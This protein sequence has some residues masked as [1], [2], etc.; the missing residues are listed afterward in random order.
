MLKQSLALVLGALLVLAQPGTGLA[1]APTRTLHAFATHGEPL[2][3]PEFKHLNYVNPQAPRGGEVTLGAPPTFDN[4][5]PFILKGV[6]APG[7]GL[8]ND[9][10]LAGTADDPE[11]L[12]GLVAESL[13]VPDDRSW[14]IFTLRQEARFHDGRPMTPADVVWSFDTLMTKGHPQYR[15]LYAD[16][17]NA[18]ALDGRRV[19]FT[20]KVA[21][22]RELPGLVGGV[23][24]LSKHYWDGRDF[25]KTTLD[26]PLGSGPY[27]IE[28]VD[29]GRS[30]RYRRVEDYWGDRLPINAGRHN[31]GAI[32]FES[33]RELSIEFEAFKA[34]AI[35]YRRE[36]QSKDWATGYDVPAVKAGIIKRDEVMNQNPLPT[37]AFTYNAR[38]ALFQDRRVRQA[39]G[40]A[41]DFEWMNKTLFYGLYIRISSYW[42]NSELAATGLPAGEERE[43]L[44]RYRGRV[45]EEVFT[46]EYK[47]PATDGSGNIRD[48]L[49]EALKLLHEAGWDIKANKLVNAKGDPFRFEIL[50]AQAG[51]ERVILPFTKNLE[52]LGITATA[53]FVDSAQYQNRADAFDYDMIIGGY[54]QSLA[55]GNEQRDFWTSASADIRGSANESGVKDP[56]VDEL[57][58][59][60]ISAPDRKSLIQRA[61]ALDRVLLWGFYMTPLYYGPSFLI[62]YWDKF[63]RPPTPPKY[64]DGFIDTWWI[65]QTKASSLAE[66]KAAM[67]N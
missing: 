28:A 43:I 38:R 36:Y 22:N 19:K 56:V 55:P 30:I 9:T 10:L 2:Y 20:F 24:V 50:Y 23:P 35:D 57:V 14:V 63:G 25:E 17:A 37:Q 16:V 34:G 1:Q 62:A 64:T 45:P 15:T 13:E 7:L 21:N 66:R 41:Y 49:R 52:R 59:L 47:P 8:I 51:L 39:L 11:G 18:A 42:T 67:K 26:P 33:Y 61:R 48:N 31:F 58:Q 32:S 46:R 60:V 65:D 54:A 40:Y 3:G 6:S 27:R 4:L 5:N 12:Y 44:E 29:P 53:R